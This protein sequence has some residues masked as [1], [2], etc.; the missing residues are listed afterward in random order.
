MVVVWLVVMMLI[1][2]GDGLLMPSKLLQLN[3][4]CL[5]GV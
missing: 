3:A 5:L 2:L 4:T 1:G